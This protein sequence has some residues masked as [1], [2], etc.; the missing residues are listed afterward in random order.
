MYL[1]Y[2]FANH[3]IFIPQTDHVLCTLLPPSFTASQCYNLR[4]RGHSLQL[5]KHSAHL[6]DS[7]FFTHILHRDPYCACNPVGLVQSLL[8]RLN[9]KTLYYCDSMKQWLLEWYLS[10]YPSQTDGW[11]CRRKRFWRQLNNSRTVRYRP[12]MPVG[13]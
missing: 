4:Q 10:L 6:L 5:P 11:G 8:G 2:D 1:I 13:S 12:Y 7:D 3:M 9:F